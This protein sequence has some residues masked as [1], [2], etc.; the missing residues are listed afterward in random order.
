[1][2]Y[3]P[4]SPCRITPEMNRLN[5]S[6]KR[7]AYEQVPHFHLTDSQY[8]DILTYIDTMR[9]ILRLDLKNREDTLVSCIYTM[10]QIIDHYHDTAV[11]PTAAD[12]MWLS[13]RFYNA[14]IEHCRQHRDVQFYAD[15]FCLSPKHFSSVVKQALTYEPETSIQAIADRFGFSEQASFARYF[16]KHTGVTPT[17]YREGK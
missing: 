13:N 1:M 2:L 4:S 14:I 10:S 9:R 12:T 16:K 5:F 6:N 17:E 7:F 15:L 8:D 3:V 11:G